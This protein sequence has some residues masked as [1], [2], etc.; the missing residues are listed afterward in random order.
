M[1][2]PISQ[3]KSNILYVD[4][5]EAFEKIE[6]EPNQ[7]V[8]AFDNYRLC[9]YVKSRD[10]CGEYSP[11]TIYFYEGFDYKVQSIDREEL[12]KKC[13]EAGLSE[14]KTKIAIMFFVEKKKPL[15]VWEW[16][17]K[18]TSK[19]WEWDYVRNLKWQLKR[20]LFEEVIKK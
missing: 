13:Q 18:N 10:W 17:L 12:I 6:L 19:N 3:I 1:N 2:I 4:S 11:V 14:L 16:S 9:F 5:L 8:L 7:A 15:E 20:K